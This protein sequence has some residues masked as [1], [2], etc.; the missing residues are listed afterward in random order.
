METQAST[1]EERRAWWFAQRVRY[2]IAL[3]IA[4][5][6]SAVSLF[7]VWALF[8]ERLPCFEISGPALGLGTIL[9][10]FGLGLANICYHLGPLRAPSGMTGEAVPRA[11]RPVGVRAQ[12]SWIAKRQQTSVTL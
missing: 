8:E 2:N 9:F 11:G 3:I 4:F 1:T 12:L 7:A 5:P 10:L 6:I